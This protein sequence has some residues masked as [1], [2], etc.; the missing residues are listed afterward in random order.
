MKKREEKKQQTEK[1]RRTDFIALRGGGTKSRRA[2][3]A[4]SRKQ[5]S[6]QAV[7]LWPVKKKKFV[8]TQAEGKGKAEK[9]P[10]TEFCGPTQNQRKNG[11]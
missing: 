1:V 7:G 9:F 2:A 5:Q 10:V 6:S 3:R 11:R 4:L 8:A